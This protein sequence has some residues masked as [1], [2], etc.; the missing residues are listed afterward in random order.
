LYCPYCETQFS[1]E[2]IEEI[3]KVYSNVDKVML[4]FCLGICPSILII[5]GIVALFLR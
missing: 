3:K 4:I 1:F 5:G 2:K